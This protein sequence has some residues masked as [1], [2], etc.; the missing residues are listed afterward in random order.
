[1]S[2]TSAAL[3]PP[4][5]A[6][7]PVRHPDAPV[8]GELLGAHYE[9]CFG[10]GG[11]QTHG[12]HLEARAGEGVTV[13]AEF[14]VQPAHQ[15]APGL[16]HGGILATALDETL[17]SLNWLLRT[18]AVTGRLETDFVRPVPVGTTLYLEAEVTAVARRK[19]YSSATGRIGGPDGPVAVRA[20]ALFIEVAVE[21][22]VNHGREAE[23]RAA[24]DDPDQ[25]RRTRA[26]E[27][28]P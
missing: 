13:T 16:A 10:C 11:A 24:M 18:I 5:D 6:V 25:R 19:I 17:G 4:A 7:K 27:V 2:G 8:P 12:L 26:F 9:H 14:T 20:D 23:I 3:E 15:G 28:N 1:M 22:F 21:H